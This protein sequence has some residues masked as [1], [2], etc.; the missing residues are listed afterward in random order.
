MKGLRGLK[1]FPENQNYAEAMIN[2]FWGGGAV[3]MQY[4]ERHMVK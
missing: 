2:F 4:I 1:F 3:Q